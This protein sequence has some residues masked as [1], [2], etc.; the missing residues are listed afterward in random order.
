MNGRRVLRIPVSAIS[1][2]I[3][4]TGIVISATSGTARVELVLAP[5]SRRGMFAA[6]M[7]GHAVQ[8]ALS[9]A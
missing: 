2:Q 9:F 3:V 7:L 1:V 6:K 8:R 4:E 5:E